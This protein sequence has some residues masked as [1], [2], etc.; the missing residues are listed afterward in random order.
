MMVVNN[1]PTPR[2]LAVNKQRLLVQR[3]AIPRMFTMTDLRD[4]IPPHLWERDTRKSFA[5][6]SRDVIAIAAL[7]AGFALLTPSNAAQY[8]IWPIYWALQGSMFF[9]LFNIGHDCGHNSFSADT[10]LNSIVGL[11]VHSFLLV[12][13][14]GFRVSHKIHH[15]NHAHPE[16]DESWKPLTREGFECSNIYTDLKLL[17]RKCF[18]LFCLSFPIYLCHPVSHFDPRSRYFTPADAGPVTLSTYCVFIWA[19][20]LFVSSIAFGAPI[21]LNLFVA[22]Y[23]VFS[24]WLSAVSY[25]H[26]HGARLPWYRGSEW[27][28]LRGCLS[29]VD[30]DYGVFNSL[31]H[32]IGTHVVH[33]IFPQ[34]PHYNLVEATACIKRV[35]G[36]WYREPQG[37][38]LA[39]LLASLQSDH[40]VPPY[41]DIVF[42]ER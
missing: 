41:G 30:Q 21:V 24:A 20:C 13:F 1:K 19:S 37:R 10:R 27:N 23:L 28:Y 34:I 32:D 15:R 4:A 29:T 36:P 2:I 17:F 5:Y 26:H 3:H 33:H 31:H 38:P 22:P 6:L 25:L 7:A 16:K 18:P 8:L 14:H 11:I 9:A 35:L 12:P 40:F 42:Y 39:R